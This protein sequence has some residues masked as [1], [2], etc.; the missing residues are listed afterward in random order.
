MG[1]LRSRGGGPRATGERRLGVLPDLLSATCY[2]LGAVALIPLLWTLSLSIRTNSDVF[3]NRL[4][5][6]TFRLSN[7]RMPGASSGSGFSSGQ[8]RVDRWHRR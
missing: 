5:P 6:H 3:S 2:L 8:R 1:G 7:F 4:L